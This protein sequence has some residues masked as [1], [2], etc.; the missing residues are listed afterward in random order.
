MPK[1]LDRIQEAL[2][3]NAIRRMLTMLR[4]G[5]KEMAALAGL[6]VLYAFFEGVGIGLLLPVLQYIQDGGR[7]SS[8]DATWAVLVKAA[9]WSHIPLNLGTLLLLSFVPILL[10]QVTFYINTRYGALVQ[11][12]AV[13]RLRSESFK[14]MI[15]ADLSFFSQENFGDLMAALTGMVAAGGGSLTYFV[16]LIVTSILIALYLAVLMALSPL[17][18]PVTIVSMLLITAVVRVNVSVA[19]R[20][21][22]E[23]TQ[24][25]RDAYI[26]IGQRL[27]SVILIK[28]RGQEGDETRVIDGIGQS[29]ART[30]LKIALAQARTD[31][32]VD[33]ALM[34]AVFVTIFVG[35]QFLG[36]Q[37]AGLGL[38]LFILLRLN[39]KTKE[40]TM[41]RQA[42]SANIESL[43]FVNETTEK[44]KASKTIVSGDLEFP[45]LREAIELRDVAFSYRDPDGDSEPVL[46]GVSLSIPRGSFAA[47]VGRSGGG[48]STL[49]QLI[50]RLREATGGTI[51]FDGVDIRDLE[52][53]SLRRRIG[54]LTQEAMLF[55]STIR[56]NLLYGLDFEPT[57][58]QIEE[59][60]DGSYS[61]TF[62][63]ELPQ[64][65]DTRVG[66]R[67][68][69]LSGG[70]KQRLALARV[71]LQDPDILILDEPTSALDSES[72]KY[73]QQALDALH[74]RKTLIVIAHR[75]STVQRADQIFVL[76]AGEIVERGTHEE[77]MAKDEAYQRL[78]DLQMQT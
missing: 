62:V 37:L 36:L 67:G 5:G 17:L 10:R 4:V 6:A 13:V 72:E 9:Q 18:T 28:M 23:A 73:I 43:L 42:L 27:G 77:L 11:N 78:F 44:A 40:F 1:V 50:P 65:L 35:Y 16:Q 15:E 64:G 56:E 54:F 20:L 71:L 41:S 61:T 30:N 74:H 60:L 39:Q 58:E 38:F 25:G 2:K 52:L 45:G 48:K 3:L 47:L 14:A 32:T 55:D 8:G 33:P 34:L 31:I 59:A 12:R 26:A 49:A 21:G 24:F 7:I 66:E 70:Q 68:A 22:V 63:Q 29:M 75:L 51:A 46:H 53:R 57:A 76:D 19:R 69:R